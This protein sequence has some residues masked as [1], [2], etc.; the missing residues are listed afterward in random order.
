MRAG[1]TKDRKARAVRGF[2]AIPNHVLRDSTLPASTRLLY[3][4]VLSYAYGPRACTASAERLCEE[5]GIGRTAFF[6]GIATLRERGL[7]DVQK[8]KSKNGW[9][10]VYVPLAKGVEIEDD[11]PEEGRSDSGR[12]VVRD[13]DEGSSATRTQ[14]KTKDEE[15][16]PS[17]DGGDRATESAKV[18]RYSGRAVPPAVAVAAERAVAAWGDATG[19]RLR[20]LDARG[21]LTQSA[22][23]IVGAMLSYPE[24]VELWQ[25]MIAR[26]LAS[27]WWSDDRPGVGVVFGPNV[28]ER[29]LAA[30]QAPAIAAMGPN[31]HAI[32]PPR[33]A[34]HSQAA[35]WDAMAVELEARERGDAG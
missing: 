34:I 12:R 23:R 1:Y 8:R 11:E 27:P 14:N 21:K 20:F 10:N 16:S 2:A 30:A 5:A 28:V 19:Q 22:S 13:T 17:Y 9:R 15:H 32:R 29:S 33:R 3:A 31:V 18:V 35:M 26:A 25:P 24:V 7:L 6:D 4:V